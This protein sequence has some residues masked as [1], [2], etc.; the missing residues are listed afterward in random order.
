[1]RF[2]AGLLLF[3]LAAPA[4][5]PSPE[6]ETALRARVNEFY[7]HYVDST[8]RKAFD[9]VAEDSKDFFFAA[10]KSAFQSFKIEN[11]QYSDGFTKAQV[12]LTYQK[13]WRIKPQFPE[14]QVTVPMNTNWKIEDGKW[15][16]YHVEAK[17]AWITPMG[18]SD[19]STLKPNAAAPKRP[20][21]S[22][23]AM[24]AAAAQIMKQTSVDKNEVTL[25]LDRASSDQVALHN[26]ANGYV[27]VELSGG[28]SIPGFSATLDKAQ[29][30]PNEDAVLKLHYEPAGKAAPSPTMLRLVVQPFNQVFPVAVK[31]GAP[32]KP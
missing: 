1:M 2:L 4:Q 8:F 25:A 6:V 17:S 16:W 13:M 15:M 11:I 26:G 22:A 21:L 3:S 28:E 5:T 18:A 24:Q 9:M 20:D 12:L 32:A 10:E 23:G 30:G 19:L 7:S 27:Q 31:F 29:L 14:T